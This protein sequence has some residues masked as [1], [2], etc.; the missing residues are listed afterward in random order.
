M[1]YIDSAIQ[2][3]GAS[4][5]SLGPEEVRNVAALIR[6]RFR[7][8]IKA[9]SA[10]DMENT[11]EGLQRSDGIE[12]VSSF[13]GNAAC[14]FFLSGAQEMKEFQNGA[15]LLRTLNECPPMEF[16][17]CDPDGTYLICWNHHEYL[18]AWGSA[19]SWLD[20]IAGG[21]H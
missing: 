21:D 12:L 10:W 20:E 15:D 2:R 13:V 16:Y 4:V 9:V 5:R 6:A 3:L 19:T 14:L 18:L 1:R 11:P 7:L 17:V 8:N